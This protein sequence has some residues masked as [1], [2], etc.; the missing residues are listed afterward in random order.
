M[1]NNTRATNWFPTCFT[2]DKVQDGWDKDCKA[3]WFNFT[4][5]INEY[6]DYNSVICSCNQVK[7]IS[8]GFR[9]ETILREIEKTRIRFYTY[10]LFYLITL[11]VLILAWM[12]YKDLTLD[13]KSLLD[14]SFLNSITFIRLKLIY[15]ALLKN[16]YL[17][18][19]NLALYAKKLQYLLSCWEKFYKMA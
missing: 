8:A 7:Y 12:A 2:S 5:S 10:S 4:T 16:S 19:P 17:N 13:K 11:M 3:D 15:P 1:R 6:D 18:E 14:D 9:E